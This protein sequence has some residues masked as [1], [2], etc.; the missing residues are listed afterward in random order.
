MTNSYQVL[1]GVPGPTII[2]VF[3]PGPS[4]TEWF[5]ELTLELGLQFFPLMY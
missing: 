2:A 1:P 5:S 3:F 4:L